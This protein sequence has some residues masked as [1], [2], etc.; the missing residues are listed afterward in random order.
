MCVV[1]VRACRAASNPNPVKA[2]LYRRGQRLLLVG[3]GDFSFALSL[4][5]SVGGA[6]ITATSFDTLP[7]VNAKYRCVR[8]VGWGAESAFV[9]LGDPLGV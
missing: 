5:A 4:A 9:L 1:C 2:G 8:A 7:D 6:G 3:E